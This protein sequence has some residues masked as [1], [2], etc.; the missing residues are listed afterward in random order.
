MGATRTRDG[1]SATSRD[2]VGVD[3][4]VVHVVVEPRGE[5]R[6]VHGRGDQGLLPAPHRGTEPGLDVLGLVGENALLEGTLAE[7]P[8]PYLVEPETDVDVVHHR[9]APR[10][11]AR[12]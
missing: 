1:G 3:D 11:P 12:R 6:C 8:A 9:G 5:R 2:G 4:D 10:A 7:E